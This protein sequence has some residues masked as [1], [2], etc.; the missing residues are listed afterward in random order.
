[1]LAH[2]VLFLNKALLYTAVAAGGLRAICE[3]AGGVGKPGSGIVSD[4]LFHGR[5]KPALFGLCAGSGRRVCVSSLCSTGTWAGASTP[6]WSCSAWPPSAGAG[7]YGTLA[8]ELGGKKQAGLAAGLC[9][10]VVNLGI[11]VGPPAFGYLVDATGSYRASW[12]L[13][14]ACAACCRGHR[15]AGARTARRDETSRSRR[16]AE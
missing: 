1:M 16:P 2:L 3:A 14:A 15:L 7:C 4:R 6:A 11:V 10:A 12:V 5:R 8:G 9:S 13:M